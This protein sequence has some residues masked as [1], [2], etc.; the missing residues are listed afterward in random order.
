LPSNAR[1]SLVVAV[2]A[3]WVSG[4]SKRP[5]NLTRYLLEPYHPRRSFFFV[6]TYCSKLL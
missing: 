4:M 1:R 6:A 2:P 5:E 3:R